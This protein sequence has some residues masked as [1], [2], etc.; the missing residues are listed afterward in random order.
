MPGPIHEYK[1]PFPARSS[2]PAC[3]Q[4]GLHRQKFI[5]KKDLVAY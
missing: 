1:R 2:Y 5:N 3:F 4:N